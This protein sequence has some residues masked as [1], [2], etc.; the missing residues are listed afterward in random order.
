MKE[1][2]DIVVTALPY[3]VS[4]AKVLEQIAAQMQAKKLPMVEDLRDESDHENPTRLVIV[5][6]SNRVNV[7]ELMAH[8]FATTDLERSYRVNMNAVGLDGRPRQFNLRDLLV[9]WLSFRAETLRRRVQFRLDKVVA[10]LHLLDGY[11]IAYL[12]IDE[13]IRIIRREDEPKPVLMKRFRLTDAQAEAILE[14]RLRHL[15]RLEEIKIRGE[16]DELS[17]E[18]S[19]LDKLLKSKARMKRLMKDELLRDSEDFGDP[20]R[21]PIVERAAAKAIDQKAMM[22]SEPITV[23]ISEKGWIRSGKGHE[24]DG[25]ALG[26][27]AGDGFLQAARG[28][29]NQMLVVIDSTGRT[30]GLTAHN[31]PSARGFGEPVSSMLSPPPGAGFAGVMLGDPEDLYL[32]ASDAG[33]GFVARLG[34]L[35]T[36]NKTGKVTLKV[37]ANARVLPPQRVRDYEEDWLGIATTEGRFL[38]YMVGELSLLSRGKGVK[39]INIRAARAAKREEFVAGLCTFQEGEHIRVF[40]GKRHL[41]LK[42]DDIDHFVGERALRGLKLP[43]GFRQVA[44]LET[45]SR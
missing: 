17:K 39:L 35:Y 43:Q 16:Q 19:L 44:R 38:V 33:Y 28:R 25:A 41:T 15:A 13:V 5:P 10:R 26:Y 12:N 20:R 30:Y 14:L 1:A 4:G 34:E 11:L 27:R 45:V 29:S 23:V 42:P 22:P 40:A 2:G 37:P 21:S 7:E 32:L 24:V 6:R 3:Q 36:R 9:E 18:R 8:L 31:L